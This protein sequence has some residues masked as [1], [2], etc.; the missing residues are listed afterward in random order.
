MN[1]LR[2]KSRSPFYWVQSSKFNIPKTVKQHRQVVQAGIKPIPGAG[3]VLKSHP[4]VSGWLNINTR[5]Y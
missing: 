2:A 4:Q 3:V 1:K 5:Q